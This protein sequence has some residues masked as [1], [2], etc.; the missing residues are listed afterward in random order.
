MGLALAATMASGRERVVAIRESITEF[1]SLPNKP[2]HCEA[3][4][5]DFGTAE[6]PWH[7]DMIYVGHGPGASGMLA[8]PWGNPFCSYDEEVCCPG[9]FYKFL[10]G[11]CDLIWL[12]GPL[13]GKTL[14][15]HTGGGLCHAHIITDAVS[16]MFAVPPVPNPNKFVLVD[17]DFGA[18]MCD[19]GLPSSHVFGWSEV[20]PADVSVAGKSCDY[21]LNSF[22]YTFRW[23]DEWVQMVDAI[24]DSEVGL[25]WEIFAGRQPFSKAFAGEGWT[26]APPIDAAACASFNLLDPRFRAIVIG[27][28]L[29]CRC[30]V[31]CLTPPYGC[32]DD[33]ALPVLTASVAVIDACIRAGCYVF[34]AAPAWASEWAMEPLK[35]ARAKLPFEVLL[36]AYNFGAPIRNWW[37]FVSSWSQ[38]TS[39]GSSSACGPCHTPVLC[40]KPRALRATNDVVWPGM[41][42]VVAQSFGGVRGCTP[43]GRTK[44]LAGMMVESPAVSIGAVLESVGFEPAAKRAR[45]TVGSRVAACIQPSRQVAPTIIPEGLGPAAHLEVALSTQHPFARPPSLDAHLEEC[46]TSQQRDPAE[47]IRY[48]TSLAPLLVE[49]ADAVRDEY[50]QWS[51]FIHARIR[52]IVVRRLVPFC[53]EVSI[54]AEWGDPTLWSGYVQGLPMLGWAEH[55][56][57][58]PNKITVPRCTIGSFPTPLDV[59][60][61]KIL[62]SCGPS[63]DVQLDNASWA[64]SVKE[65]EA[66]SLLGPF[67][68]A[69]LPDGVRLLPRRPIWE[70]HGGE[71]EDSCRNVDDALAGE[72]NEPVGLSSVHR[73]C[74]VDGLVAAGRR[75]AEEFPMDELGGFTSDFGGAYRQVPA[76]PSQ[77]EHFGVVLWDAARQCLVVGLAVA[78]L[79]GSRSAP[80]NFSRYPDWCAFVCS[81][82]FRVAMSQC[83]DDLICIERWATIESARASWLAFAGLCGWDIPLKKS[84]P[85]ARLF[86][87]LG[88]F[89]D[90]RTLPHDRGLIV[91]CERRLDAIIDLLQKV[92]AEGKL[93]SGL[94]ASIC[95]KL[96]FTGAAVAGRFG[97]AMLRAMRRRCTERRANLNPQL[98]LAID[99]WIRSLRQ[100]PPRPI[101]WRMDEMHVV[102]SYSD[103]EGSDAGVGVAVWSSRLPQPQAGRID[104]PADIRRLWTAQ[105]TR[106][107]YTRN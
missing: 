60:N 83:I 90:L 79:F 59:H 34:V 21:S 66:S 95:G 63:G 51:Q 12:L 37:Q 106:L 42:R 18:Q 82:L 1:I 47:L 26:C 92:M 107:A 30:M 89:V 20:H 48:R 41:A 104:V 45:T 55:S 87:A 29:E 100:A 24:R 84:P 68:L 70:R 15:C 77:A 58:L 74:T 53:R 16:V 50:T 9:D 11:R 76:S 8:S 75:T 28:I 3:Q 44:H 71:E 19:V 102:I 4:V 35:A 52:T 67:D 65:F 62:K 105:R 97:R 25:F 73:P 57:H 94:A 14:V 69:E 5:A 85:A 33:A 91:V 36:D 13:V 98:R 6:R 96:V 80:L 2:M 54:C 31:V 7:G 99:W 22:P 10:W 39:K 93:G 64:K 88:V 72:Q 23:P 86:R 17:D 61:A 103:G 27:L 43:A 46:Y 32:S 101:P 38:I 49:L 40:D 78:Q 56:L 81:R